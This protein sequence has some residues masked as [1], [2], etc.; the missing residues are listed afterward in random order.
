MFHTLKETDKKKKISILE[1]S[2]ITEGSGCV[3]MYIV[4]LLQI[5]LKLHFCCYIE[6]IT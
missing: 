5:V 6:P 3:H 1:V 2:E 4:V